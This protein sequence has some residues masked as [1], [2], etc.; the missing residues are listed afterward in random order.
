MAD[1]VSGDSGGSATQAASLPATASPAVNPGTSASSDAAPIAQSQGDGSTVGSEPKGP[2]PF[3]RHEAILKG[4]REKRAK[5]EWAANVDPNRYRQMSEW[6]E[7]AD[8]NPVEFFNRFKAGLEQHPT[9]GQYVKPQQAPKVDAEPEPDLVAENGQPVYSAPQMRK[10]QEWNIAK[11]EAK[12]Q[13]MVN[14]L[15]RKEQQSQIQAQA[16]DFAKRTLEELSDLEGFEELKPEIAKHLRADR[17][18]SPLGA[19]KRAYAESYKPKMAQASRDS[20]LAEMNQKAHA[21]TA[22]PNASAAT[23]KSPKDMTWEEA[24]AWAHNKK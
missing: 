14:P 9:W 6:Y 1:V 21:N 22:N 8:R 5:L 19:Y 15:L 12:F 4:E 11:T 24:L 2:I 16:Q 17:R 13:S 18:L 20:L 7:L 10:W 3:D 23:P